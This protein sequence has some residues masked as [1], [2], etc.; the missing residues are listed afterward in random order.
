MD[1]SLPRYILMH[2]HQADTNRASKML[3]PEKAC[4]WQCVSEEL[5]GVCRWI[6]RLK[7]TIVPIIMII[8]RSSLFQGSNQSNAMIWFL[9]SILL[10]ARRSFCQLELC[11]SSTGEPRP[12]LP[13]SV[14]INH[15][16]A[17]RKL[18]TAH[19]SKIRKVLLK[20]VFLQDIDF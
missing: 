10:S 18:M 12:D 3:P 6:D 11:W 20:F 5:C 8:A 9:L 17:W 16:N 14:F 7:H 15:V 13:F 2:A 19:T 1:I 4:M